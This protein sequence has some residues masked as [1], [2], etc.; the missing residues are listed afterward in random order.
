MSFPL[1][2]LAGSLVFVSLLLGGQ[3]R[4]LPPVGSTPPRAHASSFSLSRYPPDYDG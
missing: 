1:L 3:R 4:N 2:C